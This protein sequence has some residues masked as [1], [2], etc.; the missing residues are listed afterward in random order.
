MEHTREPRLLR[1]RESLDGLSIGDAFGESLFRNSPNVARILRN[2]EI[3]GDLWQ[4]TDDTEMALS[5]VEVLFRCGEI[6]QDRLAE[7]FG[8][9]FQPKRGYGGAMCELLPKFRFGHSWRKEAKKLFHGAG[10]CGNGAAMRVAP[11]GAYFAD[12]LE[13]A[14]EQAALSSEVTHAHPEG[15]AG[16]VAVA[17]AAAYAARLRG[18][19]PLPRGGEFLD[20]VI[21][22]IPDSYVKTK[23]GEARSIPSTA[24]II[25][26]IREL[27]NGTQVIAQDTV[28]F[29]LWCASHHLDNYEDALWLTASGFGD[30][31]T[32][33]AMVGGIVAAH[34]G[35]DG[36]PPEWL[37]RREP[38][39]DWPFGVENTSAVPEGEE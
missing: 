7:N 15:I 24:S 19:D 21:P 4:Y 3:A 13:K 12:D 14:A 35:M 6:D 28:P 1:T 2:C 36:L 22:H 18:A 11:L 37:K 8:R 38:L 23:T 33:C 25:R 26:V 5:I 9:Y 16:A 32:N 39:P 30:V 20:L 34:V 17:V 29:V 31:D 27:G 10:S